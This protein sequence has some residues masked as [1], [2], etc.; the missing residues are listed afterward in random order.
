MKG[1]LLAISI[2]FSLAVSAKP[3]VIYKS[4]AQ[5][6]AEHKERARVQMYDSTTAAGMLAAIPKGGMLEIEIT[7]NSIETGNPKNYEYILFDELGKESKRISGSNIIPSP[8]TIAGTTFWVS[9]DVARLD[10]PSSKPFKFIVVHKI[11]NERFEYTVDPSKPG[12]I[13]GVK[14]KA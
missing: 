1:L 5:L 6:L 13:K 3:K 14:L 11:H 4:Y 2:C 8:N 9:N 10:N 7:G 12:V